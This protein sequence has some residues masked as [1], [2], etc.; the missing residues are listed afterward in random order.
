MATPL[1]VEQLD[2][3]TISVDGFEVYGSVGG[4]V[5]VLDVT[6]LINGRG[7]RWTGATMAEVCKQARPGRQREFDSDAWLA[8]LATFTAMEG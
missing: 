1:A 3:V 4:G 6:N 2:E 5:A 7:Q 8:T